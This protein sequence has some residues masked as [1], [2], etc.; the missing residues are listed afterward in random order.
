[1]SVTRFVGIA[2]L[3]SMS[4]TLFVALDPR[5]A[6]AR[7]ID[8]ICPGGCDAPRDTVVLELPVARAPSLLALRASGPLAAGAADTAPPDST[9]SV[10]RNETHSWIAGAPA[11][12]AAAGTIADGASNDAIVFSGL[13]LVSVEVGA[14]RAATMSQS[15]DLTIRGRIASDVEVAASLSDRRLPFEPDGS[16]RELEDLDNITLSLKAPHGEATM[17]DFLLDGAPGEFA[18]LSR[19]LQGVQGSAKTGDAHWN[20]A[21]AS[22]KGEKRTLEFRGEE[23]R[24][25][26]YP[27]LT[28]ATGESNEGIVA[29]SEA[30]W[31]DGARLRRGS[32]A[33]YVIDYGASTV[34][35]TIHRPITAQSRIAV[36]FE[37]ASSRYRR[38]LY[39]ASTQ[40]NVPGRGGWYANYVSEGDDPS[41]PIGAELTADDRAALSALGDSA[42]TILPSGV[43]YAGAGLGSY[44]W[45]ESDPANPHWV[46]LGASRGTYDVDFASVGAGEGAY[47]DTTTI[48]GVRFYRY[49]GVNLG[50]YAPG[51]ALAVPSS[52]RLVDVGGSARLFGALGVDGEV[53]RSGY[54]KNEFSSRDDGDNSGVAGR[55]EARLDPRSVAIGGLKL[56]S[57]QMQG[58][59]R[60]RDDRF[61]AFDRTDPA[62]EYERWNQAPSNA[63]EDR[64]EVSLQYAPVQA[65]ALRGDVGRRRVTGGSESV[66]RGAQ[67]I[68]NS[69]LTGTLSWEEARN[70]TSGTSG[71]RSLLGGDLGREKGWFQPRVTAKDERIEGQD[72]D[73]VE[74]RWNR[75]LGVIL[76]LVPG[77][78]LKLRGGYARHDGSV[79]DAGTIAEDQAFTW[80]GGLSARLG[81]SFSVDGGFTRRRAESS[82]GPQSTNLAQLAVQAG[83]PGAPVS[84]ELRYDV[85]QLREASLVRELRPVGDGSGSYDAY[86]NPRL[87][88][89]YELVTSTGD[90]NT[91]S[92][93]VVQLRLDAFPS[94]AARAPGK[95]PAYWRG[96][97]GSTFLRVE[98]LSTLPLGSPDQAFRPDAYLDP[99]TTIRGDVTARQTLE[100]APAGRKYDLRGEVGY[101]REQSSE[102]EGLTTERRTGDARMTLRHPIPGGL[103]GTWTVTY[104]R[105]RQSIARQNSSDSYASQMRGRGVEGEI[106]RELRGFGQVS[107]LARQRRDIDLT[108]G[109]YF[110][111]YSAGPTARYAASAKLRIDARALYGWSAQ[112]GTYAPPGLYTTA[113]V[114]GRLDYD[115]LGE[116]RIHD[117]VSLSLNWTGFQAPNRP[118][119]YTGRF[120]LKGSF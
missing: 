110:D 16:S 73:S 93:A 48:E 69:T 3:A 27:L 32:D 87:G 56:G 82:T 88:G 51:R 55:F 52:R 118:A 86:G 84:S 41:S 63:G 119:Y 31:L 78:A 34:T 62:F 40:G 103:R 114:G 49:R 46:F 71:L 6:S 70:A 30:I 80:D 25:G 21:A 104:D 10:L 98:A 58:R 116:Y 64:Q 81:Q 54:D 61:Q 20:V 90:P 42:G 26:P 19:H 83:R 39:A 37:A 22:E 13:K 44:D 115:L 74:A 65:L 112:Q 15:L 75:D 28:L 105:A 36:D 59:V 53:A 23:G 66:R 108:H 60:T 101:H 7:P 89:G 57:I 1:M 113:P 79:T 5:P 14:N 18:R 67:A 111:L 9:T 120:E 94:R 35:F 11:A 95:T 2:V 106:A 47:A 38:S 91:R 24:Q 85:N 102:I 99:E 96:L 72:G 50:S 117:R 29:G 68:L 12:G 100:F 17:G 45:D 107:I 8:S 92:R 4:A 109:G 43:R 77:K 76:R 33:D 97:G